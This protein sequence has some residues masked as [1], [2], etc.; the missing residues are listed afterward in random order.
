M[1]FEIVKDQT[2]MIQAAIRDM[3]KKKV[4]VGVPQATSSNRN[5]SETNAEIGFLQTNGS[6]ARNIPPRPHLAEAIEENKDATAK[7]F[8]S[9]AKRAFTEKGII[10]KGL[11]AV[12]LMN[13]DKVRAY[14]VSSDKLAPLSERTLN[15]RKAKGF[16]GTKPLIR[17]AQYIKSI[18]YVVRDK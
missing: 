8:E 2:K 11:D 5:D 13:A 7:I 9:V 14:I 6:P 10:Q 17:T 3:T 16:L 12:G 15:E 4:F 1:S 18:T